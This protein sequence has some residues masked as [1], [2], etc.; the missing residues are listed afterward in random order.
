M[1]A[2]VNRLLRTTQ[3]TLRNECQ[4]KKYCRWTHRRPQKVLTEEEFESSHTV[5]TSPGPDEPNVI[6]LDRFESK[7]PAK[8]KHV[9]QYKQH[10]VSN[11]SFDMKDIDRRSF[12]GMD[13]TSNQQPKYTEDDIMSTT[14][15]ECGN[16]VYEKMRNNDSKIA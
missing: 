15:D 10:G 11:Y 3:R 6:E 14:F 9:F 12:K 2:F 4:A 1:S 7:R 13:V 16:Y 8:P 5:N